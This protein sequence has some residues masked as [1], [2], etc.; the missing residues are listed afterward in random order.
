MIL[1]RDFVFIHLPK[2]GGTFIRRVMERH[3]PKEWQTKIYEGHPTVEDIPESH[4]Q[5]PVIGAIRNPWSFYVSWYAFLKSKVDDYEY[6]N[7]VSKGGTLDFQTTLR[8]V[9]NTEPVKSSGWG[10]YTYFID[11]TYR[12]KLHSTRYIRFEN[13]REDFVEALDE[14]TT[15]P[16][17]LRKALLETPKINVSKHDEPA[18][19]YDDELVAMIQ[20]RDK[21][22]FEMFG[23][24]EH[25]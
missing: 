8:N 5:L 23:Y 20:Q 2:T 24:P 21:P 11:F 17:D 6:F 22:A 7:Q 16:D 14:C 19:Y 3:A 4:R 18:A 25:P 9:M 13:L 10:G 12:E 15:V 1:T